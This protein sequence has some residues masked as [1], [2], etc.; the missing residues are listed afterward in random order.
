MSDAMWQRHVRVQTENIPET[1]VW[2]P[3]TV[4][5]N[6]MGDMGHNEFRHMVCIEPAVAQAPP[7]VVPKGETARLSQTL[8]VLYTDLYT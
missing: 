6:G 8:T 7:V 4:K 1:V 5:G 3:W 2:N